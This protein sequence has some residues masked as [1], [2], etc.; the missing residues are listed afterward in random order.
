MNRKKIIIISIVVIVSALIGTVT[1][2]IMKAKRQEDKKLA[3]NEWFL[4]QTDYLNNIL[5]FLDSMDTVYSLY[6]SV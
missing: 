2:N 6:L 4:G 1:L 5:N 3:A